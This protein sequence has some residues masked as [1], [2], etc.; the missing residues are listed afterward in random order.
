MLIAPAIKNDRLNKTGMTNIKIRVSHKGDSRY[1]KTKFYIL[2]GQWKNSLVVD[3]I[4]ATYINIELKQI[5]LNYERKLININTEIITIGRL[6]EILTIKADPSDFVAYCDRFV[7]EKEGV[8]HRTAEIYQ[9]T[10]D[11]IKKFDKRDPIMFEDVNPGWLGRFEQFMVRQSMRPNAIAIPLRN[12]RAVFNHAINNNIVSPNIYPFRRFKIKQ[13]D[14]EQKGL[15]VEEIKAIRDFKT[16]WPITELARDLFMLSFYLIG[17][18]NDDLYHL[19]SITGNGRIIYQR[20][21]T[22]RKY[23]IKVE[24]EAKMLIEKYKGKNSLLMLSQQYETVH[25]LTHSI[26]KALKRIMLDLT[27]YHARHSWATIAINNCNASMDNV[28]AALGHSKKTTT[29]IYVN[30]DPGIVDRLNR[31]VLDCLK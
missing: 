25:D 7:I 18:N 11:K 17:I 14:T 6:V 27:M 20:A 2:P 21:K 28:A 5:V 12:I 15:T 19:K 9:A 13:E 4:N 1:I 10:I 24:P 16:D 8:N 30:R 26:N 22:H 31:Q 3:N 23:S 29:A